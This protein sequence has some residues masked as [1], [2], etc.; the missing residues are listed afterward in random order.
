VWCRK[1]YFVCLGVIYVLLSALFFFF[2][3]NISSPG[4]SF[5]SN[6]LSQAI[7]N[8]IAKQ[9]VKCQHVCLPCIWCVCVCWCVVKW[10]GIHVCEQLCSCMPINNREIHPYAGAWFWAWFPFPRCPPWAL[11]CRFLFLFYWDAP[12]EDLGENFYSFILSVT[13]TLCTAARLGWCLRRGR[14]LEDQSETIL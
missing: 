10:F 4:L 11:G 5:F 1:E 8:K 2:A 6:T 7:C 14:F 3:L 13:S 9:A 12:D